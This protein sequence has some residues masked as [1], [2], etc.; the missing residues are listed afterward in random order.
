VCVFSTNILSLDIKKLHIFLANTLPALISALHIMPT[1]FCSVWTSTKHGA[2]ISFPDISDNCQPLHKCVH[3]LVSVRDTSD[4]Q[5]LSLFAVNN[6]LT[7]SYDFTIRERDG[8]RYHATKN[9]KAMVEPS[10]ARYTM[11]N[12][13]NGDRLL[14]NVPCIMHSELATSTICRD[15]FPP[16]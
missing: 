1:H 3:C 15:T 12:L 13:F 5:T 8:V 16:Y 2:K 11:T 14:G 7:Y 4:D 6:R 10:G 9:P